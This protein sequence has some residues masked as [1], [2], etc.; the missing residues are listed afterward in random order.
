[1]TIHLTRR[2]IIQGAALGAFTSLL[3]GPLGALEAAPSGM[4][5]NRILIMLEL[6]GGNDGLNTL[7]PY[8]DPTYQLKRPNLKLSPNGKE[9]YQRVIPFNEW[10]NPNK[11]NQNLPANQKNFGVHF[12]L[13]PLKDAWQAGQLAFIHGV[14]YKDPNLS[15]FR[16]ID[17]WDTATDD[18]QGVSNTGWLGR[19]MS[20]EIVAADHKNTSAVL[21]NRAN[22]NPAEYS[23]IASLSMSK[24][25]DFVSYTETIQRPK[26]TEVND[27][28]ALEHLLK[29]QNKAFLAHNAVKAAVEIRP[30]FGTPFP[31]GNLGNQARYIAECIAAKL[32]C[33]FYK[34]SIK[35]FDTHAL[36][37]PMHAN[38]LSEVAQA[39]AFLRKALI[40]KNL[41]NNVLIMTYS[42][43][44]RRIEENASAGTDH[45]TAAPQIMLG[46]R[47]KGGV[48]GTQPALNDPDE[49]GNLKFNTDFRRL[50]ATCGQW[51]GIS[52]DNIRKSLDP[53][54]K[55]NRYSPILAPNGDGILKI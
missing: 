27:N 12:H 1:M 24:P 48:Y 21:F 34:M 51:L 43:F 9:E 22:H 50:Y 13:D 16:G 46:G 28:A 26:T 4:L 40:E 36:Q 54:E 3:P 38:L 7:V 47:V 45:G 18:T 30:R 52:A 37:L 31:G 11:Q 6:E 41:W 19:M 25:G 23:N 44:G 14:G 15:H 10:D 55:G 17:I 35:K 39:L 29:N 42:E 33:Y 8:L 49:R 32:P 5:E 2:H 20:K 53:L